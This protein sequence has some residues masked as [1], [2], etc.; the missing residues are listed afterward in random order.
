[1]PTP[2]AVDP[3][4]TR[5]AVLAVA[6]WLRDPGAADCP[7]MRY[8]WGSAHGPH[9]GPR[10]YQGAASK[11]ENRRSLRS[12]LGRIVL[13]GATAGDLGDGDNVLRIRPQ[14]DI[15]NP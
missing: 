5:V 8:G 12:K 1:M 14:V 3:A 6:P 2:R 7:G 10:M 9:N 13:A 11:I 15:R 4:A